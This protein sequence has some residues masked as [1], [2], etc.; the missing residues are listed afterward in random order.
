[1]VNFPGNVEWVAGLVPDLSAR[2]EPFVVD[3][4]E[5]DEEL[6]EIFIEE[7]KR[8]SG[9]LQTGIDGN[10][11]AMVR[12]AAHSIKGMGGTMGLPEISVL[13]LEIENRAKEE[14]LADAKPLVDALANWLATF[15]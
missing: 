5:M 8:L 1:M 12:M 4:D 15:Q 11:G 10:D 2:I 6:I 9:D 7:I 13:A 3:T 14:R